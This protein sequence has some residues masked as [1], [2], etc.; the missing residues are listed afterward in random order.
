MTESER[1]NQLLPRFL[2]RFH[3][4]LHEPEDR[5][6]CH[7]YQNPQVDQAMTYRQLRLEL[8]LL[9]GC[10]QGQMASGDQLLILSADPWKQVIWW[11]AGVFAGVTPGIL[12]PV[13][14]K[15]D[16]QKYFG[17][18]AVIVREYGRARVVIDEPDVDER[19][20][21][22]VPEERRLQPSADFPGRAL[23]IPVGRAPLIFQ[24]SSGTTG[25]RKGIL[26]DEAQVVAQLAHYSQAIGVS[27]EDV[28]VCWLPLYHD[29][30]MVGCLMQAVFNDIPLVLT[31][32][33]VWL[34]DP[35]WLFR[36]IQRHRGTLCWMPN[37]AFSLMADR[38]KTSDWNPDTLGSLR[39]IINCAEPV[40]PESMRRFQQAFAGIG[41]R[42]NVV[43]SCYALAENTF[44]ATQTPPGAK[45]GSECISYDA[46]MNEQKA[47]PD[48]SGKQ[49]A[50]SG[51]A[52]PGTE[53]QVRRNDGR[54]QDGAIGEIFLRGDCLFRGYFGIGAE[55]AVFDAEGWY[56][57][58]DY[59][60]FRGQELFVLGRCDDMM[61]RAGRNIDPRDIE[62]ALER[63]PEIKPGRVVAFGLPN[64]AE[65]T[66][67]IVVLAEFGM[68]RVSD[69]TQL[70]NAIQNHLWESIG[71]A[72][73]R[74]E[75]VR[76]NWLVKSSSGK[77]SRSRCRDKFLHTLA[78]RK[79]TR[80]VW[81]KEIEEQLDEPGKECFGRFGAVSRIR[82]PVYAMEPGKI[83]IGNWVSL[84]RYGKILMQTDF[85]SHE[86]YARQ[87]YPH[88]NHQFDPEIFGK[89][90]PRL[91]IGDGT[92]VGDFFF[93]NVARRVEIGK[94]VMMSDRVFITDNNHLTDHPD[95]PISLQG[96]D[97]G[98]PVII[99]DHCW[100]GI[101][102]VILPGV[103]IGRHSVVSSSSVVGCDVPPFV[104]VAGNPARIVRKLCEGGENGAPAPEP[105]PEGRN[106]SADK[107]IRRDEQPIRDRLAKYVLSELQIVVGATTPLF[108]A[109]VLD[110][111]RVLHLLD[112]VET[113]WGVVLD[114]IA[115]RR[116]KI[117][118]LADLARHLAEKT[119]GE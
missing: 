101:N 58:G 86:T 111:L 79:N 23:E 82:T 103:R 18:L 71:L 68:E 4:S 42:P 45:I 16:Q 43:S 13:T 22:A 32:P 118:S 61:I 15:L 116:E 69:N 92:T 46:L 28:V 97:M 60:Y 70:E 77:I 81:K 119:G 47:V 34:Q 88:I 73:Q 117:D 12:T 2:E 39:L 57:T 102:A 19:F 53:I 10:I 48:P 7:L 17:D 87:H 106:G 6:F 33:F 62:A 30:G 100:I 72:V 95:L 44:A 85:S 27:A 113:E 20:V 104:V 26:L 66:E 98:R 38:V 29:M 78:D 89:R 31:S 51:L 108:F 109:G 54:C 96:N 40:M 59:G 9:S 52:I 25:L 14:P 1:E 64:E 49:V 55:K 37:F 50:G 3:R 74:T 36:A 80:L 105:G 65:G 11:L 91:I 63:F 75:I 24:Q 5:V 21:T 84:G 56:R 41:L 83:R 107:P 76:D 114:V 93:F 115:L 67:D 94:H 35:A 110:S 90:D 112:W 99:E 8:E